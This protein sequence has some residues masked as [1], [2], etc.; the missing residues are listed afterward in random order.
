VHRSR[1]LRGADGI[2]PTLRL[3]LAIAFIAAV[4][5]WAVFLRPQ[6]LGG[7]A[8]YVIVSGTSMQPTLR[9]G[10]LILAL[11]RPSYH[12]GDVIGYHVPSGPGKGTLIIHRI[13]GGSGEIGFLTKG[14]NREGPDDWRPKQADVAGRMVLRVPRAGSA[15]TF[16]HT[17]LGMAALA[18]LVALFVM[19]DGRDAG[20]RA[21]R[22]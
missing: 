3:A 11:K 1:R 10:D 6:L 2:D 17:P 5:A 7:P 21:S 4:A 18:A 16:F 20:I 19:R 9:N 8:S 13:I 14:D 15:I 12:A 22:E